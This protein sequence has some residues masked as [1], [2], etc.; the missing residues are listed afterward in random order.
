MIFA[1]L[2]ILQLR[3]RKDLKC[4]IIAIYDDTSTIAASKLCRFGVSSNSALMRFVSCWLVND[5][6]FFLWKGKYFNILS[7]QKNEGK[8]TLEA[9]QQYPQDYIPTNLLKPGTLTMHR[10]QVMK[11]VPRSQD[12]MIP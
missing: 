3:S 6:N 10:V 11:G 9:N 8:L 7:K 12:P 2:V 1:Q 5:E 4:Q